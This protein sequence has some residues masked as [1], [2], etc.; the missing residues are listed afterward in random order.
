MST[1]FLQTPSDEDLALNSAALGVWYTVL[2]SFVLWWLI[3]V[4]LSTLKVVRARAE[5]GPPQLPMGEE[6]T[7]ESASERGAHWLR[8]L[9][10]AEEVG[11][12]AFLMLF[13]AAMIITLT[14]GTSTLATLT[15][16]L[17]FTLVFWKLSTMIY[18]A[19]NIVHAAFTLL[20]APLTMA[21]LVIALKQ[22]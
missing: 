10:V 18:S 2:L 5:A 7:L 3:Q 6:I 20:A 8:R 1:E 21:I 17:F 4:A 9:D 14:G 22:T 19:G 15:W 12:D 13:S 11:R 16:I